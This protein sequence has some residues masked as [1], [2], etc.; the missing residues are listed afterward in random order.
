MSVDDNMLKIAC[1]IS[2][3][4]S[5]CFFL[6]ALLKNPGG[7]ARD[8]DPLDLH[9]PQEV[10][11]TCTAVATRHVVQ[12]QTAPMVFKYTLAVLSIKKTPKKHWSNVLPEMEHVGVRS[13]EGTAF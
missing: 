9:A 1:E 13:W 6:N 2:C 3:P 4:H 7:S 12:E 11:G 10:I 5:G 8:S